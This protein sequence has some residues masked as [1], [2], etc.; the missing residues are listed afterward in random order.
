MKTERAE[1]EIRALGFYPVEGWTR[2][3]VVEVS[4]EHGDNAADYYGEMAYLL[5]EAAEE[6]GVEYKGP[7]PG[8]PFIH[9]KLENWAEKHGLYW[10][11]VNGGVIAAYPS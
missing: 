2:G 9:P 5:K 6:F 7:A 1:R 10:E 11:F 3:A 8:D 4:A